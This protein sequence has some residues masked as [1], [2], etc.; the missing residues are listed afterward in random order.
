M[1]R[2]TAL[3][4]VMSLAVT[5]QTTELELPSRIESVAEASAAAAKVVSRSGLGEDAAFGIDMAVREAVTNAVLH[6][7]RQD[8][9]KTI[10]V[11]MTVSPGAFEIMVRDRGE[12][13]DPESIPDPTDSQNVLKTSGR[14]IFF[15]RTFMD[16]VTWSRHPEG[17][18]VVRM[19]KKK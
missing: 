12:G 5:E 8:E 13:F 19:T 14:G 4:K 17:G 9:T 2:R 11:S 6:G 15:M 3:G 10:D 16:E 1:P 7:N 18:T